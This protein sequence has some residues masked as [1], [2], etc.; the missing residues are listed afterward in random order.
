KSRFRTFVRVCVDAFVAKERRAATALKR[1]GQIVVLS[2]D[3]EGADGEL[4]Q[5]SIAGQIDRDDFFRQEWIRSLFALAV[6][7]LRQ[8]F[9]ASGKSTHFLLFERYDLATAE[10]LTYAL[11]GEE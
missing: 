4:R 1:G 6:E 2:L 8:Q 7:D 11:L 10:P 9:A 5:Q 3:F